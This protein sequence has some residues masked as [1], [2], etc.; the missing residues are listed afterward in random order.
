MGVWILMLMTQKI[1]NGK[2]LG[3]ARLLPRGNTG[4]DAGFPAH[5]IAFP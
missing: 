5:G 4:N 2:H 3:K 1:K